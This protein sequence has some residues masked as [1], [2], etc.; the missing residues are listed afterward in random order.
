MK[1]FP[2]FIAVCWYFGNGLPDSETAK[3]VRSMVGKIK[4]ADSGKENSPLVVPEE[5]L[6]FPLPP[7]ILGF[8]TKDLMRVRLEESMSTSTKTLSA[9][10]GLKLM[11][12]QWRLRGVEEVGVGLV[13]VGVR[14]DSVL[15]LDRAQGRQRDAGRDGEGDGE[16]RG[17]AD[18][19]GDVDGAQVA[20]SLGGL[21]EVVQEG[22]KG[23]LVQAF[24]FA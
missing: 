4:G 24:A 3:A 7:P 1:G 13:E 20:G 19:G 8:G 17:A 12:M 21:V 15:D 22:V 5:T 23:R 10:S 2:R 6:Y 16:G 14:L 9:S 11:T 18:Q